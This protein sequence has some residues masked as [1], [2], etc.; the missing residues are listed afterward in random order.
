[1]LAFLQVLWLLP[2]NHHSTALHL[3]AVWQAWWTSSTSLVSWGFTSVLSFGWTQS[4]DLHFQITQGARTIIKP[5]WCFVY[6]ERYFVTPALDTENVS[7]YTDYRGA[8][9]D[10][11]DTDILIFE[12]TAVASIQFWTSLLCHR[13]VCPHKHM[14]SMGACVKFLCAWQSRMWKLSGYQEMTLNK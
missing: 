8:K 14:G 1:M 4:N 2:A 11:K 5:W 10:I 3:W 9:S 6:H 7:P 12:T 13:E